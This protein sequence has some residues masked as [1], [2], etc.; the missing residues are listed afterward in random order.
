[1]KKVA[2]IIHE[3]LEPDGYNILQN[4]FEAAG[5]EIPHSHVHIIPRT[6]GDHKIGLKLPPKEA[7]EEELENVLKQLK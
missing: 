2:K 7:T 1:M 5:Q 4:N 6:Y 3:K